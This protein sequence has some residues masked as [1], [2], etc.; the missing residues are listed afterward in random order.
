MKNNETKK[1]MCR[2]IVPNGL[3]MSFN[4]AL[5][6]NRFFDLDVTGVRCAMPLN[7]IYMQ[8]IHFHN[9]IWSWSRG[10]SSIH[11]T[12]GDS[13]VEL[14][15]VSH[16]AHKRLILNELATW[17]RKKKHN[18]I[19]H[20]SAKWYYNWYLNKHVAY[21]IE[22]MHYIMQTPHPASH[23]VL[24][25]VMWL[26]AMCTVFC[27]DEMIQ[28]KQSDCYVEKGAKEQE[29]EIERRRSKRNQPTE[30]LINYRQQ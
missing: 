18:R 1:Q 30:A 15:E 22:I 26:R 4:L 27:G 19:Q 16:F 12:L 23:F 7:P 5:I 10:S 13:S 8:F 24:C 21:A 20:S 29:R 28:R 2:Q 14:I 3:K 25:N 9:E 6:S 11:S 17:K